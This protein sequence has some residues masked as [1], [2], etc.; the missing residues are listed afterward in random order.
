MSLGRASNSISNEKNT[1]DSKK[2]VLQEVRE[3]QTQHSQDGMENTEQNKLI[4]PAKSPRKGHGI[5]NH[6]PRKIQVENKSPEKNKALNLSEA[7][8]EFTTQS[9]EMTQT[10]LSFS[11][12][13]KES[14]SDEDIASELKNLHQIAK[15]TG[16]VY[17]QKRKAEGSPDS[18]GNL[19][20][21]RKRLRFEQEIIAEES[22]EGDLNQ[23][24]ASFAQPSM[25]EAF[26][27]P[28]Q[29]IARVAVPQYIPLNLAQYGFFQN[30]EA[31]QDRP[32]LYI[33]GEAGN[34]ASPEGCDSILR[35][36]K[37]F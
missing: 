18:E 29:P 1:S 7:S 11:P 24:P 32:V 36:R 14:D 15:K 37:L 35:P 8:H 4:S 16:Y 17:A 5:S 20:R 2:S 3:N 12:N 34:Q 19:E 33:Y 13:N 22:E 27:E 9:L 10:N 30:P 25:P 26:H 21:V 23:T 28:V 6:S 31:Q